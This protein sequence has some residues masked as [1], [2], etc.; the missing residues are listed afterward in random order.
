MTTT[1]SDATLSA[2]RQTN[3]LLTRMEQLLEQQYQHMLTR[4]WS[5]WNKRAVGCRG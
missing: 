3:S 5:P 4:I 1:T 2:L